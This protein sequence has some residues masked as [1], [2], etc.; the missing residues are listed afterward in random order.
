MKMSHA[1]LRNYKIN[2]TWLLN[3]DNFIQRRSSHVRLHNYKICHEQLFNYKISHATC[4]DK[5]RTY[6]IAMQS[7]LHGYH[8]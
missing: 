8:A 3:D 1:W 6:M 2:Y 5:S 7:A 4:F